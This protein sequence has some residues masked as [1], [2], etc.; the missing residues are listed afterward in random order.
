M[1]AISYLLCLSSFQ[2]L[3]LHLFALGVRYLNIKALNSFFPFLIWLLMS[4]ISTVA[5][6]S[7]S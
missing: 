3:F 6:I 4:S 1:L 2:L 7:L 5:C